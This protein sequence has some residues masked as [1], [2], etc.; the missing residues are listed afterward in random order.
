MTGATKMDTS[1]GEEQYGA[2]VD[3]RTGSE[4]DLRN[5][6]GYLFDPNRLTS[7]R[8][9][10]D[11]TIVAYFWPT[12]S[13]FEDFVG[14]KIPAGYLVDV[15]YTGLETGID[16]NGDG[17]IDMDPKSFTFICQYDTRGMAEDFV[18]PCVP[19]TN[20]SKPQPRKAPT[21][22]KTQFND[23]Q[24]GSKYYDAV[25]TLAQNKVIYGIFDEDPNGNFKPDARLTRGE[26][27]QI[28]KRLKGVNTE[29]YAWVRGVPDTAR[30]K[31]N[32]AIDDVSNPAAHVYS[33]CTHKGL[34]VSEGYNQWVSPTNRI[35]IM[36]A[37][38]DAAK[39]NATPEQQALVE[40]RWKADQAE[41]DSMIEDTLKYGYDHVYVHLRAPG[42]TNLSG[43]DRKG[44]GEHYKDCLRNTWNAV[45]TSGAT[46]AS[47]ADGSYLYDEI[48]R[49]ELCLMLY[50][51]GLTEF[52]CAKNMKFGKI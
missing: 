46:E 33:N 22:V 40:Q 11:H 21:P 49:G 37:F 38:A 17:Y 18:I 50:R 26:V 1:E 10:A 35:C 13:R 9:K 31:V 52:G 20:P 51:F 15:Y 27:Q 3:I 30:C 7:D 14:A 19:G 44:Q 45:F 42:L 39:A 16:A 6:K 29:E 48:T 47:L 36:N 5:F 34:S 12:R 4:Q 23:V 43:R 8:S 32:T 2:R 41:I 28:I 24:P 25:T